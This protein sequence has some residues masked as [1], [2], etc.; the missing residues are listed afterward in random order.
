MA[1]DVSIEALR[2]EPAYLALGA[3]QRGDETF[4]IVSRPMHKASR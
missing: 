4:E 3:W 2:G 1:N